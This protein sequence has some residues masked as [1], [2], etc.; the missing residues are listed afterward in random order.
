MSD[1]QPRNPLHG[2]TLAAI[3]EELVATHGWATLA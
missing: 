2:K 3:L 1:E